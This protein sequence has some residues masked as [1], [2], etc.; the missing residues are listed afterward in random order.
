[1]NQSDGSDLS[2]TPPSDNVERRIITVGGLVQGVGFRPFVYRLAQRYRLAGSVH[3][4][5]GSVRIDIEGPPKNL[6]Q[7]LHDLTTDV[8]PLARID[9]FTWQPATVQGSRSFQIESSTSVAEGPIRIVPDLAPCNEC[10]RELFDPTDRRFRYPFLNCTHCGP[11]LTIITGAPYDRCRTTLAEFPLC[12]DCDREYHDPTNRRFHAQPIACPACGPRL[13]LGD[14]EGRVLTDA[15][16]LTAFAAAIRVGKIGALKGVGGYHL[17][18]DARSESTV[19]ELRRRKQREEKPLAVMVADLAQAESLAAVTPLERELLVSP[20][21]PIVLL[22]R[23]LPSPLAP[24]MAPGNPYVGLMLPPSPLHELLAE[25]VG[26]IPLVMTS[27]NR[28]DEPIATDDAEARQ[29]LDKIADLFLMHNRPIHVRCDD[30]VTRV[31][32]NIELPIRR[33]RGQAPNTLALPRPC[34]M[35]ILALGGQLK[36][37]FALGRDQQAILSHHL[38]DLDHMP[39]WLAYQRDLQLY[40][41]LFDFRPRWLVHDRHPDYATT[42]YA[43]DRASQEGVERLAVQHHHAHLASCL[44]DNGLDETVIGVTF[45]GTGF[46]TDGAI[47]GGEFLVGDYRDF[48]RAAHLRYVPMPG[49]EQ[50]IREPWRM[51]LA[52][53]RDAEVDLPSWEARLTPRARR[54]IEQMLARRLQCPMTSSVGRLFD[55]VASLVGLADRVSYEGHAAMKLEWLATDAQDTRTYPFELHQRG[56]TLEIDTRPLIAAVARDVQ[57]SVDSARIAWRFHQSVV[58]MIVE[59]CRRLREVTGRNAVVLSGGV[60]LN[61]WLTQRSVAELRAAGFRVY[62]HRQVPPGDGGLCLGQLAIA[63]AQSVGGP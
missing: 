35:P 48:D 50:A 34:P 37:V 40:E 30:S 27:G 36:A 17:V 18:C 60:F 57:Q 16:P 46:G 12:P 23:R 43:L 47:W 14:A 29:R 1:M 15:D 58:R 44:A 22:R 21:R 26:R 62:R 25:A 20:R 49:G 39:A 59:V 31:I 61:A 42:R 32:D 7:F 51:A 52:H 33:S 45:D 56:G 24:S 54:I 53:L 3:N 41:E 55:A 63:A 19:V 6:D 2:T 10:L 4:C 8:P 13:I 5:A 38:G 9:E 11:R 28:S